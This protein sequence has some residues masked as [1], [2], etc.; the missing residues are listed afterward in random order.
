[1][2]YFEYGYDPEMLYEKVRS[3]SAKKA[4]MLKPIDTKFSKPNPGEDQKGL[5]LIVDENAINSYLLEL[6]MIDRSFSVSDYF[7]LDP[8][9]REILT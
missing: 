4:S 3:P 6:V 2:D 5:Q 8:R 1:M 9:T 7:V